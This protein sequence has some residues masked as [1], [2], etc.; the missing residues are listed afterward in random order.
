MDYSGLHRAVS[1][2]ASN[3]DGAVTQDG[4]GFNGHDTKFGKRAAVIPVDAWTPELAAEV[5]RMLPTYR[6]QLL[7]YGIDLDDIELANVPDNHDVYSA[8][9]YARQTARAK[10]NPITAQ[11]KDGYICVTGNTYPKK[12]EIKAAGFRWTNM[13]PK[14]WDSRITHKSAT[15]VIESDWIEADQNVIDELMAFLATKD[16]NADARFE[17]IRVMDILGESHLI[18]ETPNYEVPINVIRALPGREWKPDYKVNIIRPTIDLYTLAETYKLGISSEA[19]A[20]IESGRLLEEATKAK[21]AENI[22]QSTATDTD[23]ELA[24]TER[25]RPYQRAGVAFALTHRR[26]I[27]AD[28]MGLGKTIQAL[29][30]LENAGAYPALVVCPPSLKLNW[31]KEISRWL[32]HRTA[33]IYHSKANGMSL[34]KV[35]IHI[36]GY[37]VVWSYLPYFPELNGLVCDESHYIKNPQANRAKAILGL[38]GKAT[39]VKNGRIIKIPAVLSSDAL[40]VMLT[41]TPILNREAE[42]ITPLMVLGHL[43]NTRRGDMNSVRWFKWYYCDNRSAERDQELNAWL[44]SSGIMMRREV[45]DVE[46]E[47]PPLIRVSDFVELPE[48][49]KAY[50]EQLAEE[51]AEKAAETRAEAIVY[52]NALRS[53]I[54]LAKL[55]MAIEQIHDYLESTDESIIV[56]ADHVKVQR[57]IIDGLRMLGHTVSHILGGQSVEITENHK[58]LFQEFKSRVIVCSFGAAREGHTLTAASKVFTVE[59]GWNSGSHDQAEKRGHRIGQDKKVTA[60]YLL[61]SDTIDEWTWELIEAK[62]QINDLAIRGMAVDTGEINVFSEVLDRALARYGHGVTRKWS[63]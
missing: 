45:K 2:L 16:D 12:D 62:R 36:M 21:L 50:Y 26:V 24:H 15:F 42:L 38:A 1:A 8:R 14:S 60:I 5:S 39:E 10:S 61:A 30:A 11:I 52:L 17:H 33:Y 43:T 7:G 63:D 34:P 4:V 22:A 19:K 55:P 3:C 54:G 40:I 13:L 6:N 23:M 35:D 9:D 20:M 59:L 56:F 51:G 44:R 25:L 53:A 48:D 41:G 47:L 37:P 57:G 27:I 32:P 28:E 49:A 46:K 18:L 31:Q 29:I 58:S